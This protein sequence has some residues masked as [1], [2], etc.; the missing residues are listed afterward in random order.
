MT[1]DICISR[2][3]ALSGIVSSNLSLSSLHN[4]P[5]LSR[6]G[7]AM[8]ASEAHKVIRIHGLAAQ[9]L[10]TF[11]TVILSPFLQYVFFKGYFPVPFS[12]SFPQI[13]VT[14]RHTHV[15]HD[16]GQSKLRSPAPCSRTP[17]ASRLAS[18]PVSPHP[19]GLRGSTFGAVI[20]DV[21]AEQV[22]VTEYHRGLQLGQV[23][24]QPGQL[25]SQH[26]HLRDVC[27]KA[28]QWGGKCRSREG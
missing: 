22:V 28:R 18:W 21:L 1:R 9:M 8:M 19:R 7:E 12:S 4:P 26:L 2:G 3:T 11:P 16:K 13:K 15:F 23:F 24:L 20:D 10:K 25:L 6:L 17:E 14:I 5:A 27:R